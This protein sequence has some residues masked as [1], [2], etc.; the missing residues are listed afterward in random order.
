MINRILTLERRTRAQPDDPDVWC[1][2]AEARLQEGQRIE[3]L[4]AAEAAAQSRI[5][6]AAQW[7]RIGDL[8]R[9][10][11]LPD[12]ARQMYVEGCE[13]DLRSAVARARL[14]ESLLAEGNAEQ[15]ANLFAVGAWLDPDAPE[16]RVALARALIGFERLEEA[17][18]QLMLTVE[19][20]PGAVPAWLLLADLHLD[21][22]E[23]AQ[24][25]AV[26][27]RGSA[28]APG[29]RGLGLRL[30]RLLLDA[31]FTR[32]AIATLEGVARQHPDAEVLELLVDARVAAGERAGAIATLRQLR[33]KA[34]TPQ[35]AARLG[36]LLKADEQFEE[37]VPLLRE[38]AVEVDDPSVYVDLGRCLLALERPEQALDAAED[39]IARF[40]ETRALGRLL[41]KARSASGQGS[42]TDG[43]PS[44]DQSLAGPDSAF[45]G[46]L[47]Q[48]KVPDLL[49]FL[50]M[51]QRTGVLRLIS[52]G[53]MG[54]IHLYGG[55]LASASTSG[56]TR[57][58]EILATGGHVDP[59][60]LEEAMRAAEPG[61]V[62][63]P[64]ALLDA[65]LIEAAALRPLLD[66]R[67]QEAVGDILA[68]TDGHF[69]FE[70]DE[71]E[72]DPP[73]ILFDT[74]MMM[75]EAFRLQDEKQWAEREG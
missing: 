3:A 66:G 26:L 24:A 70:A 40:G 37:A 19:V 74:G 55:R 56:T 9:D 17:R 67:I 39:G 36:A 2:L 58:A 5:A 75:L 13:R 1:D 30:A 34:R 48:F 4:S 68:W 47:R 63:L 28:A 18:E 25:F 52:E 43:D 23:S 42:L 38:A 8:F 16:L 53:R 51:N 71:D 14:G 73:A 41:D 15:A 35:S 72:P 6:S 7:V 29:D 22:G 61:R 45:A 62:P 65:G 32:D 20:H 44:L 27:R 64:Q 10:L 59:A 69:A 49:E 46:N 21:R 33:L 11:S 12:H 57:L 31:G 50:R 54:E 60:G